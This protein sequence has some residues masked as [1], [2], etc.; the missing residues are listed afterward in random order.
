MEEAE[1]N[2]VKITS[3]SELAAEHLNLQQST[4]VLQW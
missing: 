2:I 3:Q 4:Q 1:K